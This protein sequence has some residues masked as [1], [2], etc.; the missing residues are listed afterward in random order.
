MDSVDS[1]DGSSDQDG[2]DG[3]V[4]PALLY[5]LDRSH[6][7]ATLGGAPF[8]YFRLTF[9]VLLTISVLFLNATLILAITLYRSNYRGSVKVSDSSA[10]M[11]FVLLLALSD[12]LVGLSY[13]FYLVP[14]YLCA[15]NDFLRANQLLC[16]MKFVPSCFSGSMSNLSLIAISVDRYIAVVHPLQYRRIL[17][18]RSVLCLSRCPLLEEL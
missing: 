4:H 15:V 18:D 8:L 3:Q 13:P 6:V 16:M 12:I 11:K 7:N 9:D 14:H 17:T 2:Q 5:C 10:S 1:A